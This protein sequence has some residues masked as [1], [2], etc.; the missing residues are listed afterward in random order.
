MLPHKFQ[1]DSGFWFAVQGD[2]QQQQA[3]LA[4]LSQ[5]AQNVLAHKIS[6]VVRYERDFEAKQRWKTRLVLDGNLGAIPEVSILSDP[7]I[8]HDARLTAHKRI[9]LN[10]VTRDLVWHIV[11]GRKNAGDDSVD[12]RDNRLE[13]APLLVRVPSTALNW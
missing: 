10:L 6:A 13:H 5:N 2:F 11:I 12:L 9:A 4:E 8:R 3:I 1:I 7:A